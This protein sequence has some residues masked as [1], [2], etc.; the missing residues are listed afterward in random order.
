MPQEPTACRVIFDSVRPQLDQEPVRDEISKVICHFLPD[1]IPLQER[2]TKFQTPDREVVQPQAP[3]LYL[4]LSTQSRTSHC[5]SPSGRHDTE[6]L[7]KVRHFTSSLAGYCTL[8]PLGYQLTSRL[9]NQVISLLTLSQPT[10]PL[11][12]HK[13]STIHE[14]HEI[15][16]CPTTILPHQ[17]QMQGT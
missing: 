10:L 9:S 3:T 12:T 2:G 7:R 1:R 8:S 4:L 16:H 13:N 6:Y 11:H 15:R 5:Y 14:N 17:L